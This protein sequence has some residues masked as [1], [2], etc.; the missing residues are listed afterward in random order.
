MTQQLFPPE[1]IQHSTEAHFAANSMPFKWIYASLVFLI[2]AAMALLPLIYVDVTS[3]S[4]G[5][6]RTKNESTSLMPAVYGKVRNSFLEEGRRVQHGDT[7]MV[8]VSGRINAQLDNYNRT[9]KMNHSFLEDLSC[10]IEKRPQKINTSKYKHEWNK[11][12]AGIREFQIKLELLQEDFDQL[13]YLYNEKVTAEIDY[14]KSKNSLATAKSQLELY[15]QKSQNAWQSEITR[16]ELENEDAF[17]SIEQL[18]DEKGRYLITAPVSGSL[19]N[20]TGVQA[21]SFVSPGQ[22]LAEISPD[23]EL[24]VECY[25]SPSDIGYLRSGQEVR[26][27]FDAFDYNQ[28]GLLEG[29]VSKISDDVTL[30]DNQPFFKVRCTLPESYLKLKSGQEGY[31]KKGM[32]LTGRFVLNRRTLFQLLFDKVDDWLNPKII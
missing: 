17:S 27:Q 8:L 24:I 7:L 1:I 25:V 32:T 11:Y 14:L 23:D 15:K 16:I 9:V 2:I 29:E 3:Q 26:F 21:G 31:L 5:V 12:K 13:E 10:L 4:S 20:V 18:I 6:V 30:F 19:L 22:Q 28:W